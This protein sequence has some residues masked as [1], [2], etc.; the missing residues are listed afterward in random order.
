MACEVSRAEFDKVKADNTE[1]KRDAA[2]WRSLIVIGEVGV[3]AM[4]VAAATTGN[5][6]PLGST[7]D[8]L[9]RAGTLVGSL[10]VGADAFRRGRSIVGMLSE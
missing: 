5:F 7:N 1:L 4:G 2:I 9:A 8:S 3:G 6:G 10:A